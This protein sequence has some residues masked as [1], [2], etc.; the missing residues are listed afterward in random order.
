[1]SEHETRNDCGDCTYCCKVMK[2]Q[3]LNKAANTW[4]IHC[5]KGQGCAIYKERP[6][7]CRVYE[8]LWLRSQA[9]EQPL[10]PSLRPDRSRVVIGT[11]N[12]GNDVVL[13]VSP[14]ARD[15]WQEP[16]FAE[17]MALFFSRGVAVHVSCNDRLTRVL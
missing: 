8:C 2:V 17:A 9:F 15:A 4:C 10:A 13:Y 11:L 7:S 6:E 16:A 5:N 12:Q 14:E 3:E 1:M